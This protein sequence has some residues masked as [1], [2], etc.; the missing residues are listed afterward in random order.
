KAAAS[1]FAAQRTEREAE[2]HDRLAHGPR[3]ARDVVLAGATLA[4]LSSRARQ[5]DGD[6]TRAA[7]KHAA[8][9]QARTEAERGHARRVRDA[10]TLQ[11]LQDAL[12]KAAAA[13]E[14][15]AQQDE[16]DEIA[17][18]QPSHKEPAW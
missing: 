8:S 11:L 14:Q 2:I 9:V 15:H 1:G 13:K 4:E 6:I 3:P 16:L 5:L 12:G 18:R 17:G 7:Q 10:E